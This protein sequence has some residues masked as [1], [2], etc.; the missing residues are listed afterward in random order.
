MSECAHY[1]IPN[2]GRGGAAHYSKGPEDA[3]P[4]TLGRCALCDARVWFTEDEWKAI[5]V[6]K[7]PTRAEQ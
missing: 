5:P 7:E 2:N 1:F 3:A 6:A 4:K